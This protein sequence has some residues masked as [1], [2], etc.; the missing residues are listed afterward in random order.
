[1]NP[2]PAKVF[3]PI[4]LS[5][6]SSCLRLS[7]SAGWNQTEGDWKRIVTSP[8]SSHGV[9]FDQ[10]EARAS[11]SVV[12]YENRIC[13]IG[14]ILVDPEY[15]G[16]GL[17]K[18]AFSSS[19]AAAE[20]MGC[21]ISGLD[22]TT[23]GEPM[24][25]KFGFDGRIHLHRMTGSLSQLPVGDIAIEHLSKANRDE[26]CRLD[27]EETG[28]NRSFIWRQWMEDPDVQGW[29][30]RSQ[31]GEAV[32]TG[33]LRPGREAWHLGP[34]VAKSPAAF[35]AIL[36]STYATIG[37]HLLY[38]D[39]PAGGEEDH[40]LQSAGLHAAR[41]LLRMTAPQIS[42]DLCGKHLWCGAGFEWG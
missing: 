21:T 3:R 11:F 26:A 24:Y 8:G 5:D 16:G 7:T 9:W 28:L 17:G 27:Q 1:M 40:I 22:A 6:L 38:V 18:A 2:T 4:T 39:C 10:G 23:L 12:C 29:L 14:M 36:H 13:W 30:V 37:S 25:R 20:A 15:R 35:R 32:G 42:L 31:E 34:V 19:L 33:L 41:K